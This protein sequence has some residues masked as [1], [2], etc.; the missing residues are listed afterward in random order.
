MLL[1]WKELPTWLQWV[2]ALLLVLI[3]SV[4]I[5]LSGDAGSMDWTG[6]GGVALGIALILFSGKSDA[7]KKGYR[8][9]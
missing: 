4:S 1:W 9:F 2:V 7:E 3:G 8:D 5:Y 6:V